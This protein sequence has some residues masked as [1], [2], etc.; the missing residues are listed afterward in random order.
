MYL[1]FS[2]RFDVREYFKGK[3]KTWHGSSR[4]KS[5]ELGVFSSCTVF[6]CAEM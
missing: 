6:V 4:C 5:R 2:E 3:Q 1:V